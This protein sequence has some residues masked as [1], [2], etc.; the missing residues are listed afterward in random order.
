MARG[1]KKGGLKINSINDRNELINMIINQINSLNKKIKAF[2]NEGIEEHSNYIHHIISDDM[3]QFTENGTLSKSKKFYEGEN[4]VWLKKTLSALHKINNHAYYGTIKKY[5]K[6]I[7]S[8][9][10]KVQDYVDKYLTKKGYNTDFI[11]NAINSK[12]FMTN[13]FDAYKEVGR[14]FG[15]NQAIEKIA[16][17]YGGTETG[18]NEKEM[19]KILSNIEYAKNVANRLKEEQ[20]AFNEFMAMRNKTKR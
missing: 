3:G 19:N 13:L 5:Q 15:S 7:T 2:K 6:E 18:F 8:T 17:N 9:V 16:L 10:K 20:D 4:I 1:R 11:Y 14:G 12:E